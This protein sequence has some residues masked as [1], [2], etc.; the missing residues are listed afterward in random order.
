MM[1]NA[2]LMTCSRMFL[3]LLSTVILT[4]LLKY[5]VVKVL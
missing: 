5:L 1:L 2:R 3:S 4:E